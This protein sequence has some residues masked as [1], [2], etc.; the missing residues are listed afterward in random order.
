[1]ASSK[2]LRYHNIQVPVYF[3]VMLLVGCI[4]KYISY[5]RNHIS[6]QIKYH[7]TSWNIE[8]I[9]QNYSLAILKQEP[10]Y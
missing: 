8:N 7:V 6:N 2:I 4:L 1:M 10:E 3:D 9:Y 5:N